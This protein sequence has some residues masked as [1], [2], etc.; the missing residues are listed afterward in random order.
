M[1]LCLPSL[2][3]LLLLGVLLA[4]EASTGDSGKPTCCKTCS[5]KSKA[6]GDACVPLGR[7]CKKSRGCACDAEPRR[8]TQENEV[9]EEEEEARTGDSGTPP[10]CCKTCSS[11]SK[12]CGDACIPVKRKCSKEPGCACDAEPR[13]GTHSYNRRASSSSS[14]HN[15][16]RPSPRQRSQGCCRTC[17]KGKACGDWCISIEKQ[18]RKKA[19]CACDAVKRPDS[20]SGCVDRL[21]REH[22]Q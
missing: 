18:C 21:G 2:A 5:S 3:R 8:G 16:E 19:G 6:C 9:E 13:Q 11:K 15:D 22:T 20:S 10:R 17:R 14:S 12:A 1:P 7:S 4:S